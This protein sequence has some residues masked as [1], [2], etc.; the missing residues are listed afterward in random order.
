VPDDDEGVANSSCDQDDSQ[1]IHE[2]IVSGVI[3]DLVRDCESRS[4]QHEMGQDLR[5]SFS[6]HEVGDDDA[7]ETND[8]DEVIDGLHSVRPILG[9]RAIIS[10]SA[11]STM[12]RKRKATAN[13]A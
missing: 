8:G 9:S 7:N 3:A 4:R 12:I 6:K 1:S 10:R 11:Y 13:P 2:Q 5:A